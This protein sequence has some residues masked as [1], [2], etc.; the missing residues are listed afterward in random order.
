[1]KSFLRWL[2][3]LPSV[4]LVWLVAVLLAGGGNV[5]FGLFGQDR[6][7]AKAPESDISL[8]PLILA[9]LGGYAMVMVAQVVAPCF[10][11][12]AAVFIAFVTAA[13]FVVDSLYGVDWASRL[14]DFAFIVGIG[15]G[16]Y[17]AYNYETLTLN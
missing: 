6:S 10:K 4:L 7:G 5:I 8:M 1:M 15:I 14:V 12:A 16:G 9:G 3:L 11:R 13:F 2:A 17:K